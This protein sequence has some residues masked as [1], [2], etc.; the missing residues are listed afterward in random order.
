MR[1]N[2][3]QGR[4]NSA[5]SAAHLEEALEVSGGVTHGV[6]KRVR[7]RHPDRRSLAPKHYYF[8][9][10]LRIQNKRKRH[11][12]FKNH[13]TSPRQAGGVCS[14]GVRNF[15]Q[16]SRGVGVELHAFGQLDQLGQHRG[17]GP[18]LFRQLKRQAGPR[19]WC[20]CPW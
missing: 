7:S 11:I 3:S 16:V 5:G 13:T 1:L 20:R 15:L 10:Y 12:S 6:T 17:S 9:S 18:A 8:D 2:T 14:A 4:I 19:G